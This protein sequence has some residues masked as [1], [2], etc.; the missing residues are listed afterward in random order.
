MELGWWTPLS[1]SPTEALLH[2]S[3]KGSGQ[4]SRYGCAVASELGTDGLKARLS[5][6]TANEV[7]RSVG[8]AEG[9]RLADTTRHEVVDGEARSACDLEWAETGGLTC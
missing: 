4:E 6:E 2:G 5:F 9:G 8:Y 1:V 3:P 7:P